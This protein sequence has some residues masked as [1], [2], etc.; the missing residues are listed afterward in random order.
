MV[1]PVDDA[2]QCGECSGYSNGFCRRGANKG[3]WV[4]DSGLAQKCG[5]FKLSAY[6]LRAE[7][8]ADTETPTVKGP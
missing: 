4:V 3:E 7:K 8:M 5:D 1:Q 6:S 2:K